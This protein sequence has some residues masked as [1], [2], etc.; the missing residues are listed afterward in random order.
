M[1]TLDILLASLG[2]NGATIDEVVAVESLCPRGAAALPLQHVA[3]RGVL[4]ESGRDYL[5]QGTVS[6]A[7]AGPCARCLEPVKADFEAAVC[8]TFEPGSVEKTLEDELESD[9]EEENEFVFAFEGHHID[10]A[11]HVWE[12]VALAMPGKLLCRQECAGLCTHCGA[13]L[14]AGACGCRAENET[15]ENKGLAGLADL[16]PKLKPRPPEE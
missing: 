7:F 3:V 8:W 14:N 16:L 11:P 2:E 13:N 12:E 10:L 1:S 9:A 15:L 5:F 4:S 6:G